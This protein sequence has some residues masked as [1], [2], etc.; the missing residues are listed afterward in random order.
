MLKIHVI[1][2]TIIFVLIVGFVLFNFKRVFSFLPDFDDKAYVRLNKD[3]KLFNPK[4]G[5]L[6]GY[7][8][9]GIVLKFPHANDLNDCD[10]SDN[11]RFK[12]LV[13]LIDFGQKD[14]SYLDVNEDI[15]DENRTDIYYKLD[16][17]KKK[18]S[19]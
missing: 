12:V 11:D 13:D 3:S 8:K 9:K 18:S 1:Y 6:V 14:L 4:N 10:L 16:L 17:K 5:E 2:C 7:F 15:F 19:D